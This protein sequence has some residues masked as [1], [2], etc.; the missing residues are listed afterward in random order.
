[1][2]LISVTNNINEKALNFQ[3]DLIFLFNLGPLQNAQFV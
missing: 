2:T 3:A 1:M